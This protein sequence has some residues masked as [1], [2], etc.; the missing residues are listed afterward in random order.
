MGSLRARLTKGRIAIIGGVVVVL[1]V[2]RLILTYEE[3]HGHQPNW[4]DAPTWFTFVAAALGVPFAG[5]QFYQQRKT[6][7][8]EI[9]RQVKRDALLDEQLVQALATKTA[10]LRQQAEDINLIFSEE[11]SRL[12]M[13][14]WQNAPKPALPLKITNLAPVTLVHSA[15]VHNAS[16]RPIRDVV[17]WI[18]PDPKQGPQEADWVGSMVTYNF[19]NHPSRGLGE[20]HRNHRVPLIRRDDE[21]SFIFE[22]AAEK[23]PDARIAAEFT[24]DAGHRWRIDHDLSLTRIDPPQTPAS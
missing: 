24:D 15:R 16:R 7:S 10:L 12:E 22:V 18:E 11:P 19:N 5:Y 9:A 6:F 14:E 21:Y 3:H 17:C 20:V 4:G 23:H 2:A 13:E 1:V 8:E